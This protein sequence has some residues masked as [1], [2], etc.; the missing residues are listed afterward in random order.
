MNARLSKRR[1]HHQT[2]FVELDSRACKACWACCHAC[3]R[4]VLGKVS[5]LWH[6]HAVIRRGE[7]CVGCG[8]C[9]AVC[10]AGA[11]RSRPTEAS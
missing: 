1:N 11:L 2:E 10:D 9:I 4:G 6:K 5:V 7:D 8:Q 3:P